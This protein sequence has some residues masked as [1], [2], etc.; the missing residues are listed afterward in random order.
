MLRFRKKFG[1]KICTVREKY[2]FL[3]LVLRLFICLHVL[4]MHYLKIKVLLD[5]I[6]KKCVA[7][8]FQNMVQIYEKTRVGKNLSIHIVALSNSCILQNMSVN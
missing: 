6:E 4:F 1:K 8:F 3:S 7:R 2:Q 5:T